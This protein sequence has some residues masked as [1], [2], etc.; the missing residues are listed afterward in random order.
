MRVDYND[1]PVIAVKVENQFSH[2]LS[3]DGE[4]SNDF[5]E[6]NIIDHYIYIYIDNLHEKFDTNTFISLT[7]TL[8]KPLINKPIR[9]FPYVFL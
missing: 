3:R 5:S 2:Y 6:F 1:L 4:N 7:K 8:S 9:Y